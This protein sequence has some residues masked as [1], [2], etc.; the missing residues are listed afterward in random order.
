MLLSQWNF[1]DRDYPKITNKTM[2]GVGATSGTMQVTT[3][4]IIVLGC[5]SYYEIIIINQHDTCK[6][7][8]K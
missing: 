5:F 2:M 4:T 6:V 3:F 8:A 1:F 7:V